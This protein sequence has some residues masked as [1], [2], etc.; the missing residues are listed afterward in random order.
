VKEVKQKTTLIIEQKFAPKE[1][2]IR[3]N[4]SRN[5][6]REVKANRPSE[7]R[8]KAPAVNVND[9]KAFPSLSGN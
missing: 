7:R 6:Q 8:P 2:N 3:L 1:K 4:N 5:N 9:K